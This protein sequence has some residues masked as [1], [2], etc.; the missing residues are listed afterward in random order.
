VLTSDT[1]S[2]YC[3][4]QCGKDSGCPGEATCLILQVVVGICVYP[5]GSYVRP[6]SLAALTNFTMMPQSLVV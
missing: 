3:A 2:S 6:D 5:D 1:G 4:L